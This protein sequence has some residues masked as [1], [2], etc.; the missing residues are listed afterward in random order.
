MPPGARVAVRRG[1]PAPPG[2]CSSDNGLRPIRDLPG[3]AALR[4]QPTPAERAHGLRSPR[5]RWR[6]GCCA[7]RD[8][9]SLGAE[10]GR[11]HR[12]CHGHGLE[13]LEA[14][15]AAGAE[16]TSTAGARDVGTDVATVPVTTTRG[17]GPA[18]SPAGPD[19]GRRSRS[20]VRHQTPQCGQTCSVNQSAASTFGG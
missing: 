2:T 13:N 17:C 3:R 19:P 10:R 8:R 15:A 9:K 6:S 16:S 18:R 20:R 1:S 12:P 4:A 7:R 14:R 11:D 5:R